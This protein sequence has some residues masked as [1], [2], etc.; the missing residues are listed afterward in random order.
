MVL[1]VQVKQALEFNTLFSISNVMKFL[2]SVQ[3]G[4]TPKGD[5]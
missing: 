3:G 5:F 4:N 1:A 2:P